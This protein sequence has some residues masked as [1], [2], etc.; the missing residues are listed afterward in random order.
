LEG[1]T[2]RQAAEQLGWPIGTVSGRLSRARALLASRLSRHDTPLTTGA[3]TVLLAHEVASASVPPEL[4]S[5][6]ARAASLDLPGNAVTAG[7]VSAEVASL[8]R[9]VLK[10]M[11]L[12]KLKLITAMALAV[13]AVAAGGTVFTDGAQ[14][15]DSV[16]QQKTAQRQNDLT[17]SIATTRTELRRQN[18][19][20]GLTKE[21]L[22]QIMQRPALIPEELPN[23]EALQDA[24]GL[25]PA[26]RWGGYIFTASP[27]GNRA[28]AYN[29]ATR[30]E[31]SVELN[32]TKDHPLRVT[33]EVINPMSP[34]RLVALHLRGPRITRVALF[35][36]KLG[37]WLPLDLDEP[38]NGVA[39]P[40]CAYQDGTAYNLRPHFYTFRLSDGS[41]DHFDTRTI[42]DHGGDGD[43]NT[44]RDNRTSARGGEAWRQPN[45]SGRDATRIGRSLQHPAGN[46]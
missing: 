41:W 34:P 8:T 30:E 3:L 27:T 42:R 33:P 20:D 28:I 21:E 15:A 32:A 11:L 4:V 14:I 22:L 45:S 1:K 31:K 2:H 23:D 38:V 5:A 37:K 10:A 19:Q 24:D 18:D 46:W 9:E 44:A 36:L 6:A 13:S 29:P 26:L 7:A 43:A 40:I 16:A 17:R 12:K 35:D 25:Q 39:R